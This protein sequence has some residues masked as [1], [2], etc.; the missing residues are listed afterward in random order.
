MEIEEWDKIYSPVKNHLDENASFGGVMFETYGDELQFV[1]SQP[2]NNVW[3]YI[4]G[5]NGTYIIA[6][7]QLVNRIGYFITNT[8]WEDPNLSVIVSLDRDWE[9]HLRDLSETE[10][11]EVMCWDCGENSMLEDACLVYM[12]NNE[13]VCAECCM[14]E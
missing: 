6:G 7:Y 1:L 11:A 5:D 13:A 10:L 14:C 9:G 8:P 3:T 2:H 12:K 4:Q